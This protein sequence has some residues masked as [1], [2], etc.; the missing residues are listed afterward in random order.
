MKNKS[1]RPRK[2]SVSDMRLFRDPNQRQYV[3]R[4]VGDRW[5]NECLHPS[6][7]HGLSWIGAAFQPLVLGKLS[8]SLKSQINEKEGMSLHR[9][10]WPCYRA[11]SSCS[12]ILFG[13]KNTDS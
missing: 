11:H 3:R 2:L 12:G 9:L 1:D 13:E 5:K 10:T 4:A 7:K 8:V 6:V